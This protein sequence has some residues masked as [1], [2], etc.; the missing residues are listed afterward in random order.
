MNFSYISIATKY[1]RR[2]AHSDGTGESARWNASHQSRKR[3][4]RIRKIGVCT[5]REKENA[6]ADLSGGHF[7]SICRAT[8]GRATKTLHC[9]SCG[10]NVSPGGAF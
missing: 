7:V 10:E 3:R 6:R 9:E 4:S 5:K 1:E 8:I 2:F